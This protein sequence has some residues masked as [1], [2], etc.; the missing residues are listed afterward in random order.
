MPRCYGARPYIEAAVA[1]TTS[2]IA[3]LEGVCDAFNAHDLDPHGRLGATGALQPK[4]S[5][6]SDLDLRQTG[7][8]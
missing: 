6:A 4:V 3:L 5:A 2:I 1:D 8:R 7:T